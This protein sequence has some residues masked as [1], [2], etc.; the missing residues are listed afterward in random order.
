MPFANKPD[1]NIFAPYPPCFTSEKIKCLYNLPS[2]FISCSS[3]SLI[4]CKSLSNLGE[5][6]LIS[7]LNFLISNVVLSNL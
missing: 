1:V 3:S 7:S 6:I 4:F 5:Y 2:F